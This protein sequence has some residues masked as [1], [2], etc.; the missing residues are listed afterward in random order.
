[1]NIVVV[2]RCRSAC[3]GIVSMILCEKQ[4]W[5]EQAIRAFMTIVI[6]AGL[7]INGWRFQ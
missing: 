5:M 4:S 1:M 6:R 3:D 7:I 2:A